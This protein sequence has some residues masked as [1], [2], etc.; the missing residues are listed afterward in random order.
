MNQVNVACP[1]P[2]WRVGLLH[3][4]FLQAIQQVHRLLTERESRWFAEK[5]RGRQGQTGSVISIFGSFAARSS[6]PKMSVPS[7]PSAL[8]M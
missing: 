8:V 3:C 1:F 4:R 7:R 2:H 5:C 6:I